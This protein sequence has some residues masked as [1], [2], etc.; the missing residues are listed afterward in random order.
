MRTILL[1]VL[2][3]LSTSCISTIR[4]PGSNRGDNTVIIRTNDHHDVAFRK[5]G[6]LLVN[7]GFNLMNSDRDIGS[8][9]T[10]NKYIGIMSAQWLMKASVIITGENNA[11]IFITG[12]YN[13]SRENPWRRLENKGLKGSITQVGWNELYFVAQQYDGASIEFEEK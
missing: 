10:D 4:V 1:I 6:Q 13:R 5:I 8:I 3:I 11:T 12:Q 2:T 7:N 9:T